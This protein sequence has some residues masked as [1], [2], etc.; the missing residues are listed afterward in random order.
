MTGKVL[1]AGGAGLVGTAIIEAL[2]AEFPTLE[3]LATLN[4][5]P[6]NII[7]PRV[8]YC[9]GDILQHPDLAG[10]FQGCSVALLAVAQSGGVASLTRDPSS[11]MQA[12]VAL[13]CRLLE[14]CVRAGVA[15]IVLC[16][17][18][19]VYQPFEGFVA[20][21]ELDMNLDPPEPHTGVGWANRYCERLAHYWSGRSQSRCTVARLANVFGAFGVFDPQRSN[22]IP[23]LVRKAVDRLDPF[24][25][26]GSPDVTRD[27]LYVKD[28]AQALISLMQREGVAFD[29][30]NVGSGE[31]TTVADAVRW[32]LAAAKHEPEAIAYSQGPQSIPF[33]A[34]NCGKIFQHFGWRPRWGIEQGIQETVR[35]WEEHRQNWHR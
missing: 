7:H 32:A 33:R 24:E 25:V 16:S 13:N 9:H 26:W 31:K 5:S 19:T 22:F 10:L 20:E 15:H 29:C 12:T 3:I 18:V 23:A 27:V 30:F 14:A 11:T 28:C 2:L 35:W 4:Q 17:S 21:S 8:R 1:V 6:P 34:L